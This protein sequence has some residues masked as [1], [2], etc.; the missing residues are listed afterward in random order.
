M[1]EIRATDG[2]RCVTCQ[3]E[4]GG[5]AGVKI[6]KSVGKGGSN[7]QPDVLKIQRLLNR[8]AYADGGPMPKLVEDSYIGFNTTSAIQRFQQIKHTGSDARVDPD[9][10]TLKAMNNAASSSNPFDGDLA[11]A[12]ASPI[13]RMARVKALM[14]DLIA[15]ADKA[16]RAA[17]SAMDSLTAT[18]APLK[19]PYETADFYFKFGAQAQ[20]TTLAELAFIRTT[21]QRVRNVLASRTSPVTGGS[22]LGV[23][24]FA[25]DPVG[26][27]W[28]AYSPMQVADGSRDHPDVHSGRVYLC[29]GMDEIENN[30]LFAHIL[31]HEL[32]HFVDDE[33][34]ARVI[35]DY[36]YGDTALRLPHQL[37]MRNS[38]NY[39]LFASH[40]YFG[41]GRLVA[42]QP[43][44]A[45]LVPADL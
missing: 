20:A 40:V 2:E 34:L 22:S 12:T 37:R 35:V 27:K 18:L 33:T 24:I 1:G 38:D 14:P 6:G 41:R 10:A 26:E 45:S 29:K 15:M 23:S 39:A 25:N 42:S 8:I 21:F 31:M 11:S 28:K 7:L 16:R 4:G 43:K 19:R 17:E 5:I 3:L 13:A 32:V 44:L 30:D 36:G 9:G